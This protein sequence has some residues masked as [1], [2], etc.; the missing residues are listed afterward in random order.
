MHPPLF[1]SRTMMRRWMWHIWISPRTTN[2]RKFGWKC[3]LSGL[4]RQ[5]SYIQLLCAFVC[6][7]I[8][9]NHKSVHFAALGTVEITPLPGASH[10]M[11]G[12]WHMTG[13]RG[14]VDQ[15]FLNLRM[16]LPLQ[17]S[18]SCLW[19]KSLVCRCTVFFHFILFQK[20]YNTLPGLFIGWSCL[21]SFACCT[22]FTGFAGWPGPP[23]RSSQ[24]V[25]QH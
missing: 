15:T 10:G 7:P 12:F 17:K 24:H 16:T 2:S 4:A 13:H 6:L 23:D 20:K 11:P 5:Y 1:E 21:I 19:F 22:K 14:L 9:P 25:T 8:Y 3:F 18:S